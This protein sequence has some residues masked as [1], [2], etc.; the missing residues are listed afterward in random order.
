LGKSRMCV[1]LTTILINL[2][3]RARQIRTPLDEL[4]GEEL[5]ILPMR[6]PSGR[7]FLIS[8]GLSS[9]TMPVA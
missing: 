5:K 6:E 3:K 7:E 2:R 9:A 4:M 8:M 1:C